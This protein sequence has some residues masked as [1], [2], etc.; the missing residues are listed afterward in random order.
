M[1]PAHA[2][3]AEDADAGPG[4]PSW[5]RAWR[6]G[7]LCDTPAAAQDI[8]NLLRPPFDPTLIPEKQAASTS[9][10]SFDAFVID[11]WRKSA[12]ELDGLARRIATLSHL[13][14]PIFLAVGASMRLLLARRGLLAGINV[15]SRPLVSEHFTDVLASLLALRPSRLEQK[16]RTRDILRHAPSHAE[17]LIAADEA[18]ERVLTLGLNPGRLDMPVIDRSSD[19]MIGSLAESGVSGWISGVRAHHDNTFQH[20]LL[21][22]GSAIAFGHQLGFSRSDLRRVALGALLHDVGK[23]RIPIGILD[24]PGALTP[25]ERAVIQRHPQE[26]YDLIAGQ[27]A[28]PDEVRRIVMQHH[29]FLDGSGYPAGLTGDSLTDIVRLVTVA[30]VFGALIERRSY[31]APLTG[32]KAYEI[33]MSMNGKLD[34]SIVKAVRDTMFRAEG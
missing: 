2:R 5:Q 31:R 15:F 26:G 10:E 4:K 20:C 32:D 17:A 33:M 23:S 22:T 28:I 6:V 30:D 1:T 27:S 18:L 12:D 16:A 21:V 14:R 34:I 7:V 8:R 13:G 9:W 3:A 24:K 19:A 11:A 29:E 25:E